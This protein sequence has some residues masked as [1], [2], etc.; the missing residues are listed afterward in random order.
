MK[1]RGREWDL[2]TMLVAAQ[3]GAATKLLVPPTATTVARVIGSYCGR[4]LLYA[5]VILVLA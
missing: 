2:R 3:A 1:M 4:H 5:G